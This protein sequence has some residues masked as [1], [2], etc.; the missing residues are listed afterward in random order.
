[1]ERVE[2]VDARTGKSI[3]ADYSNWTVHPNNPQRRET[4]QFAPEPMLLPDAA[5]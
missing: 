4:M 1:M 3:P 2:G 5:E